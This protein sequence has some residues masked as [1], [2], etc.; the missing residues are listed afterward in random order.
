M[1]ALAILALKLAVALFVATKLVLLAMVGVFC[2][3]LA[4]ALAR[5]RFGHQLQ[6]RYAP[7]P[8]A[9]RR[10]GRLRQ[11]VYAARQAQTIRNGAPPARV[12]RLRPIAWRRLP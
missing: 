4:R 5:T 12:E 3:A 8:Y 10:Q 1:I 9:E 7:N 6:Q 11:R 2:G